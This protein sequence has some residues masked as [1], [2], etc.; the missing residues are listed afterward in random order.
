MRGQGDDLDAGQ[1]ST[2][3]L[4][5][6]I[7]LLL[8]EPMFQTD[9]RTTQLIFL[10]VLSIILAA[11]AGS[12]PGYMVGTKKT[13]VQADNYMSL[14]GTEWEAWRD[15]D[16]TVTK[17]VYLMGVNDAAKFVQQHL[18][19][20]CD[21]AC[22]ASARSATDVL[23]SK[24]TA[25]DR[26]NIPAWKAIQEKVKLSS[27]MSAQGSAKDMTATVKW[28]F[29][30]DESFTPTQLLIALGM[31]CATILLVVVLLCRAAIAWK[32]AKG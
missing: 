32:N 12:I 16:N 11:L 1:W 4:G 17:D 3:A 27:E 5:S 15:Q 7:M 8:G 25:F 10:F 31:F 6:G 24:A 9:R 21:E 20:K 22:V 14:L 28:D 30:T 19:T 26:L 29:R 23:S 13:A 2:F 18:G